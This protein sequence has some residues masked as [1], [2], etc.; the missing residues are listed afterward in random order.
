MRR[1]MPRPPPTS[2]RLLRA[3]DR[4]LVPNRSDLVMLTG[5]AGGL[6]ISVDGEEVPQI[7]SDGA[8]LHNVRLDVELLKSGRAVIR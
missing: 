7:G 3:G 6:V 1:S 4:Y 5:N 8:I 2:F